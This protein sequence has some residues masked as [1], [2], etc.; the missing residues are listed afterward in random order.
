MNYAHSPRS[1]PYVHSLR[2]FLPD[3]FFHIS[4]ASGRR[5]RAFHGNHVH[6]DAVAVKD[7]GVVHGQIPP[8]Q[9]VFIVFYPVSRETSLIQNLNE[10]VH[11]L[12]VAASYSLLS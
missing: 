11:N 3:F 2:F 10:P 1:I 8:L 12:F 7:L 5:V 4:K 6:V 9:E